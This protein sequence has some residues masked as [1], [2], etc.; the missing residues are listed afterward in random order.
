MSYGRE[1][2]VSADEKRLKAAKSLARLQKK[3]TGL[4][5]VIIEG[6]SIAKSWWGK[7][8]MT[9][10]ECYADYENRI[11][12]GKSYVRSNAILD[13]TIEKGIVRAIVQGSRSKPYNV[14]IAIKPVPDETWLKIQELTGD[15]IAS[16]D[17]LLAGKFPRELETLLQN[18]LFPTPREIDFACSCPDWANMCKHVAA[19][20]Y[21]IAN[22]LDQEPMLFFT[23][24]G[25]DGQELIKRGM[26][27]SIQRMLINVREPSSR[28][29]PQDEVQGLFR[30][31]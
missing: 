3:H 26:E 5:P 16:L 10:L 22:R 20:L 31:S 24:R 15:E 28:E 1:R 27:Q 7:A 18:A 19:V 12:R 30:L 6:R 9:N 2:Y 17:D 29:I 8:W 4:A 13:L 23:L 14:S 21:G 11:G 25:R